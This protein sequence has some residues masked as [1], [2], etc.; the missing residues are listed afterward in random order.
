MLLLLDNPL[1]GAVVCGVVVLDFSR[2]QIHLR[3][4][5]FQNIFY[6]QMSLFLSNSAQ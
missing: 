2:I 5:S 6:I 1:W 4:L 3:V